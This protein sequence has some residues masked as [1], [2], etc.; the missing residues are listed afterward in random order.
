[1]WEGALTRPAQGWPAD[2]PWSKYF[3]L[4][5]FLIMKPIDAD[6]LLKPDLARRVA[7]DFRAVVP[8]VQYLNRPV[9]Y[10]IEEWM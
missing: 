9:D 7:D 2:K 3:R 4:K 6:Y 8:F 10:A 1:M 5:Q